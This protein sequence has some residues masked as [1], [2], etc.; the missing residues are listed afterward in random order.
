MHKKLS[1]IVLIISIPLSIIVGAVLHGAKIFPYKEL[2]NVF[3]FISGKPPVFSDIWSIGIYEG[4][5]PFTIKDSPNVKNPVLTAEHVTDIKCSF[6]ADPFIV[7]EDSVFYMFFEAFNIESDHADIGLA[8]SKDGYNWTYKQIVLDE[9]FQLSYPHVFK[10]DGE[11]YMIPETFEDYNVLLYRAVEFPTRWEFDTVLVGGF[12]FFD[13]SI[14]YYNDYWWIFASLGH[15]NDDLYL[16]YSKELK[17][18]WKLH[19][20]RPL[21][22]KDPNISRPAGNLLVIDGKLYRFAQDDYPTYG[23]Q[24]FAFEIT[25]ITPDSYKDKIVSEEPII[26]ASGKGWNTYGMHQISAIK[27]GDKKWIATVDG[28][29]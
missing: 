4:D 1:I 18:E 8:E 29:R 2:Q 5:S 11:Y 15:E 21:I 27:L 13:A 24:V 10:H 20:K 22:R 14:V 28:V 23:I 19:K 26:S 9:E 12:R 16:F 6:V 3:R 7:K 17:G 25:E